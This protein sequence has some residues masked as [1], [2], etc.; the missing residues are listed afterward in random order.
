MELNKIY[1]SFKIAKRLAKKLFFLSE[2]NKPPFTTEWYNSKGEITIE[3]TKYPRV[4]YSIIEKWLE[5]EGVLFSVHR[6]HPETPLFAQVFVR[7]YEG[8]EYP[9]GE[10]PYRRY[11]RVEYFDNYEVAEAATL[12]RAISA[13]IPLPF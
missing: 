5:S 3:P 8:K 9:E 13:V 10:P 4:R 1:S 2:Y 11:G 6:P 12:E 7:I